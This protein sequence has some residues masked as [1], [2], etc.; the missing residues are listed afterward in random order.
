MRRLPVQSRSA[1]RVERML[2]AAAELYASEGYEETTTSLIASRAGV[3]IG[4]LYQFFPDK[5]AVFRALAL[6]HLHAFLD[7]LS[8]VLTPRRL[9]TWE[10]AVSVTVDTYV[11]MHRSNPGFVGFGEAI[12]THLLD[13]ERHNNE[14]LAEELVAVWAPRFGVERPEQIWL[15][16]LVTVEIGHALV[17]LA[18]RHDP[19]GDP[20][21]I[22]EAKAALRAYLRRHLPESGSVRDEEPRRALNTG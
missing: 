22:D 11:D 19:D 7:R 3:S 5:K 6:R 14:V 15:G 16:V 2:D 8:T 13:P 9:A 21:V 17:K 10:D 12:D 1:A 20:L 18:F 4:S